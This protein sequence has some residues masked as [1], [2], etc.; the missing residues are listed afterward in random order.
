[1]KTLQLLDLTVAVFNQDALCSEFDN[2]D[3]YEPHL[4]PVLEK[5]IQPDFNIVDAGC[6]LGFHTVRFSKLV[7]E[8]TV[9]AFDINEEALDLLEETIKINNLT[10]IKVYRKGLSQESKKIKYRKNI[11]PDQNSLY[12]SYSK[13]FTGEAEAELI[14]LDKLNLGKVHLLKLDVEG[15][16]LDIIKGSYNTI[17]ENRPLIIYENLNNSNLNPAT[18]LSKLEYEI[19]Q[20]EPS[21]DFLAIPNEDPYSTKQYFF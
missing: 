6:H 18:Y 2:L 5:I 4:T 19:Y 17:K 15:S 14:T 20:I 21:R 13:T 8:G 7:P 10:N 11:H 12:E 16:E 3:N 9:H 1:M